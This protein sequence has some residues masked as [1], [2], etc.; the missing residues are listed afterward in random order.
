[1][2]QLQ[3]ESPQLRQQD[4]QQV[5]SQIGPHSCPREYNFHLHTY[6]SDGQLSPEDLVKQA[7]ELGLKGLA[8]TDHH[9]VEAFAA[10]QA[11]VEDRHHL[12]LWSGVEITAHLL[13]C[14]VHILGY[15]FDPE[16][17][18]LQPFLRGEAVS[19]ASAADV[20]AALHQAEGLAV[21][22]HPFR[23]AREAEDLVAAVVALG[24]DGLEV[25]YSYKNPDPWQPSPV[26]TAAA[27]IFA[28]EY[29]L[30]RTCGTDTHGLKI[31]RRV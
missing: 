6:F 20:I 16:A 9:S 22:A 14:E 7:V 15:A 5:W 21:L 19:N 11:C 1:M 12:Q 10:A 24:I 28:A 29:G 4:L 3:L 13:G 18:V 26:Q 23:Y 25:Y 30:Y 17:S 31:T 8:I 2:A 27:E